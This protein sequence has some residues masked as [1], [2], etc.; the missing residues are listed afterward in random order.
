[1]SE[2]K[3]NGPACEGPLKSRNEFVLFAAPF[4]GQTNQTDAEQAECRRLGY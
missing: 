4:N 1:M 3:K 2:M